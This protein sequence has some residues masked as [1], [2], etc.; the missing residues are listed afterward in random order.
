MP[1]VM[2]KIYIIPS[3]DSAPMISLPYYIIYDGYTLSG[4]ILAINPDDA[5]RRQRMEQE[6]L[7]SIDANLG[8]KSC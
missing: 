4:R 7:M 3:M 1:R 6:F 5:D 2:K 8:I